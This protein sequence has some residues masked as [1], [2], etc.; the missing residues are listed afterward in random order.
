[1]SAREVQ[2]TSKKIK[3]VVDKITQMS[4]NKYRKLIMNQNK[5]GI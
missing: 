1:M 2:N 4:Y 3:K 5:R